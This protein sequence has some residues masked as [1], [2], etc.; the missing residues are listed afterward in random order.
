[1]SSYFNDFSTHDLSILTRREQDVL[2][3]LAKG[4]SNKEI[5]E[6]LG[7]K[8]VTVK[9]HLRSICRKLNAKNRTQAALMGLRVFLV[10]AFAPPG[11]N[12]SAQQ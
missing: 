12:A 4:L 6:A 8:V 7:I 9:M 1:M 2:L 10:P 5:G 3:F 11:D